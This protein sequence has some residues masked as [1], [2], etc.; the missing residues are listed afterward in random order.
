M[1]KLYFKISPENLLTK[2]S[3][4]SM[5]QTMESETLTGLTIPI[6]LT[7]DFDN[8]GVY[9]PYDGYIS[10]INLINNFIYSGNG[11]TICL[12][13]TSEV[14]KKFYLNGTDYFVDW[15]D[16]TFNQQ[17]VSNPMCHTYPGAGEY[18]IIL[19]QSNIWGTTT[20]IKK[21][22]L[23]GSGFQESF[24]T[25]LDFTGDSQ[26]QLSAHCSSY[27][28]TVP[29]P[30]TG[31][32]KSQLSKLRLYGSQQYI[33]NQVVNTFTN[34][35]S[36]PIGDVNQI[37]PLFTSYTVN[38]VYY[39]DYPDGLTIFSASSVGIDCTPL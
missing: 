10:Q 25:P 36:Q 23:T 15:G 5:T 31:Y 6:L 2:V 26:T 3:Y 34:G 35:I 33:L 18:K 13:N 28:T 27:Y 14:G 29:F 9:T 8:I 21:L 16:I 37:T 39:I 19:T 30:V 7:Q 11:Y 1:E 20:T 4:S 32:T 12:Y 17:I 24:I 38:G 22:T